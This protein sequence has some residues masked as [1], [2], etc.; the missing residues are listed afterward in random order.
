MSLFYNDF[1]IFCRLT[2]RGK[3][4]WTTVDESGAFA[5]SFAYGLQQ[6]QL[7]KRSIQ[8]VFKRCFSRACAYVSVQKDIQM[9][10]QR[11]Q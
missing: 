7:D 2:K 10:R 8:R 1:L 3:S 6:I 11:Y 5:F 4:V 9:L